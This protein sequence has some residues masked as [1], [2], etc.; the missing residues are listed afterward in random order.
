MIQIAD[1][2]VGIA[3]N[4]GG[5]A[6]TSADFSIHRFSQLHRI[7][8]YHGRCWANNLPW[9]FTTYMLWMSCNSL[10]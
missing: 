6:S 5:Q 3:G 8:F 4:E 9:F 1:C 10:I 7:I 2:G